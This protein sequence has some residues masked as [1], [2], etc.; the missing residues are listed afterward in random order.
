MACRAGGDHR[1]NR[2]R[3]KPVG[4]GSPAAGDCRF[5]ARNHGHPELLSALLGLA[6]T[7]AE[8]SLGRG[9][10]RVRE[11]DRQLWR[12]R[13]AIHGGVLDGPDRNLP[14]RRV[15]P[16]LD[17]DSVGLHPD[18]LARA[19]AVAVACYSATM[20]SSNRSTRN[21]LASLV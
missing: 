7:I 5:L 18:R 6:H 17:G 9:Q 12:I 2:A 20:I 21:I 1:R 11:P 3:I 19:L 4:W 10:F 16:G 15:V 13:R 14:G 8:R